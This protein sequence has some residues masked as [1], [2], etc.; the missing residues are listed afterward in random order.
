MSD[1]VDINVKIDL[2][3]L[4]ATIKDAADLQDNPKFFAQLTKVAEA[5]ALVAEAADKVDD[6][7]RVAKL[8][9]NDRAKALYGTAWKVVAGNGYKINRKSTGSLYE[10]TDTEAA[11]DYLETVLKP[12]TEK[13][14]QYIKTHSA[15]PD[16]ISYNKDR[17]ESITIKVMEA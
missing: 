17:G 14:E 12:D 5:K 13:L 10:V 1:L 9:I 6:A 11:A 7:E 16:G 4:K 2:A 15:L 8:A 3:A